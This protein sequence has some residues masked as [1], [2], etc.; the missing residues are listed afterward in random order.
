[1]HDE[2]KIEI[3]ILSKECLGK[4]HNRDDVWANRLNPRRLKW[5]PK[6]P[7]VHLE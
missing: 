7:P 2:I 3:K 6:N 5:P 1:M 4:K